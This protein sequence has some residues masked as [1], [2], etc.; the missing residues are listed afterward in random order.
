MD[1]QWGKVWGQDPIGNYLELVVKNAIKH[2]NKGPLWNVSQYHGP[3]M[4]T[5]LPD[6]S[7]RGHL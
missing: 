4:Y 5:Q 6:F 2:K 3:S 7:I 1:T